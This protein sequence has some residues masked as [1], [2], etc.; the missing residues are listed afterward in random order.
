MKDSIEM[1][2]DQFVQCGCESACQHLVRSVKYHLFKGTCCT[3]EVSSRKSFVL[4]YFF[5]QQFDHVCRPF[6]NRRGFLS[7]NIYFE[8]PSVVCKKSTRYGCWGC[9]S[10]ILLAIGPIND[11]V[12]RSS[13]PLAIVAIWPSHVTRTMA[14]SLHTVVANNLSKQS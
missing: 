11:L 2:I 5:G 9:T 8:P 12:K 3:A 13:M 1:R 10:P 14:E 7:T 6:A 4:R